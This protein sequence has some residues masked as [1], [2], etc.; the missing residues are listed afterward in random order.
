MPQ[1]GGEDVEFLDLCSAN[2]KK[3]RKKEDGKGETGR[4]G[5]AMLVDNHKGEIEEEEVLPG[6]GRRLGGGGGGGGVGASRS[7]LFRHG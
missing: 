1:P 3:E 5:N 4:E 7:V 6:E 2:K